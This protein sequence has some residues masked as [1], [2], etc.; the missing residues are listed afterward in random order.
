MTRASAGIQKL[1]RLEGWWPGLWRGHRDRAGNFI[2]KFNFRSLISVR[3]PHKPKVPA[4]RELPRKL[5]MAQADCHAQANARGN[6]FV[7]IKES[8]WSLFRS[9][10]ER[11]DLGD[12]EIHP[13]ISC[14]DFYGMFLLNVR[15]VG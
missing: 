5:G 12:D 1:H 14:D 10:L 13:V 3:S 11:A 9:S 4:D 8:D 2:L 6:G 15:Q 7:W